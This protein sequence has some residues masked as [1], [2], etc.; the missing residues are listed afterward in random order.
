MKISLKDLANQHDYYASKTNYY[1]PGTDAP[2]YHNWSAFYEEFK[3]ADID[4]NLVIRWDIYPNDEDDIS[5]GYN[6]LVIIIAQGKGIYNP[7]SIQSIEEKDVPQIL[8]FMKPHFE[9]LLKNWQPL[10][11]LFL[12]A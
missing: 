9:K 7:V 12:T 4:M 5:K 8:S 1:T 2:Q 11:N 10:S 3:T 6:M